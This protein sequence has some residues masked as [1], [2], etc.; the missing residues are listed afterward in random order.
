MLLAHEAVMIMTM[1][2]ASGGSISVFVGIVIGFIAGTVL[3]GALIALMV[4]GIRKFKSK[5]LLAV[6]EQW[7]QFIRYLLGYQ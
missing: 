4:F 7:Y 3:V 6:Q 1:H 2:G 5:H